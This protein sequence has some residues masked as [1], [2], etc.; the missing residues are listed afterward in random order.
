VLR[1]ALARA[2][3]ERLRR[4]RSRVD[5]LGR[6]LAHLDPQRVLA[7]GYAIVARAD[8]RVV[9]D[10]STLAPGDALA[11]AL[12]QGRAEATVTRTRK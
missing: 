3:R 1:D 8:G 11:I 9:T 12:A 4:E 10:A 5:S 2:G 6:N 7:R